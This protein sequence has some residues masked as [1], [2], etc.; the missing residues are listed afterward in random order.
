MFRGMASYY[1]F[2]EATLLAAEPPVLPDI[3]K[4]H[5]TFD[6]VAPHLSYKTILAIRSVQIRQESIKE[7]AEIDSEITPPA[8]RR[9]LK[10]DNPERV[11]AEE[12]K[13]FAVP[14]R[15]QIQTSADKLW[16]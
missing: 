5:R 11:A 15:D 12:Q 14:V 10:S 4:D 13:R 16:M 2:P 8:L 3:P 9:Y 7:L 6:G 1:G